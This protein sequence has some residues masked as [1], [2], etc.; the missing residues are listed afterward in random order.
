MTRRIAGYYAEFAVLPTESV[1]FRTWPGPSSGAV[2]WRGGDRRVATA[3][4][5]AEPAWPDTGPCRGL[6]R[7]HLRYRRDAAHPQRAA[8][9]RVRQRRAQ[10]AAARPLAL[11]R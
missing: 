6:Q 9:A 1:A 10:P 8:A 3:A 5:A 7:R 4:V 11:V 2:P